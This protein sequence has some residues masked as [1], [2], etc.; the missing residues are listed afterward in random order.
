M[1]KRWAVLIS[2]RGS[3]L[4]ALLE[5]QDE[6]QTAVVVSSKASADGLLKARRAGVA[7]LILEK[8]I[9][10]AALDAELRRRRIT[11]VCLAGFMRIVPQEFVAQWKNR[12]VNLHPSLLPKY[13]GLQSIEVAFD[14]DD[15]LGVTVHYVDEGVDTGDVILQSRCL[16][17]P[18]ANGYSLAHTEFLVHVA[19]QR[20]LKRAI[21]SGP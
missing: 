2:G 19:E 1:R 15:D 18:K 14:A 6:I 16:K 4:G 20:L 8:K 9:D 12:V 11:H 7:T 17:S 13:P 5:V 21:R 10:W 3:N